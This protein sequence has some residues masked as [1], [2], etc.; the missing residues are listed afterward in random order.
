M[1]CSSAREPAWTNTFSYSEGLAVLIQAGSIADEQAI[2]AW[3]E[4]E[5]QRGAV[6]L[7]AAALKPLARALAD[8]STQTDAA[9][10]ARLID[11]D[12][13]L[14]AT[15]EAAELRAQQRQ[16]GMSLLQLMSDMGHDLPE[17]VALS[18]PAAWSWAAVGLS[19]SEGDMVEGY[20]YGWVA[21]QLSASVRLLPLIAS[22]A[23]QLQVADPQQ[24]WSSGVGAG[25]AQLAHAELYS[26]L[27]RS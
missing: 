2:Q 26:R 24:L 8:W 20:L 21:N 10:K 19:V 9:A 25:M 15:R 11:L 12:G 7:E 23:Q 1:A 16:M 17:P 18:W 4:A 27:F 5:L 14:L 22:Q 13:W 3:L 6:R